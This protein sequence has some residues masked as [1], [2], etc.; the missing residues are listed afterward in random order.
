MK[1]IRDRLLC[2]GLALVAFAASPAAH[3]GKTAEEDK[4]EENLVQFSQEHPLGE[5]KPDQALIY[6]VRPTS[7]GFAVKSWFFSDDQAL[8]VNRGSSY[9]FA[10]VAPGKRVF[11]SKSENVDAVELE[12]EAGKT[13]YIQQHVKIGG[14]KARTKLEV[15]D[16][17]AGPERLAKCTKYGVLTDKGRARGAELAA[18]YQDHTAEDLARR[19]RKAEAQGE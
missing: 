10:H 15:L 13:Y 14:F 11:W 1:P 19:E 8:G 5:A 16:E 3:A 4:D 12:V 7:V 6:V 2:A 17:T 18:E 9:F